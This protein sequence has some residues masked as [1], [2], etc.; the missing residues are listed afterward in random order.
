[1]KKGLNIKSRIVQGMRSRKSELICDYWKEG[2]PEYRKQD[3]MIDKVVSI[4]NLETC[5]NSKKWLE[6]KL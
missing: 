1:M 2:M 4:R 3:K 5:T 6:N